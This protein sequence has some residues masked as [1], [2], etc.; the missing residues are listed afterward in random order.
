MTTLSYFRLLGA[1][2]TLVWLNTACETV[3][4]AKLDTSPTQ[5]SIDGT[6]TDQPG[7]QTVRLSLTAPYFDSATTP[8]AKGATVTVADNTGRTYVFTD[9]DNDG[10]YVWQPAQRDTMGRIGRTYKLT[11]AY[12]GDTYIASSTMNRVPAIDSLVFREARINP[13]SSTMGYRASFYARDF[14]GARDYYRVRFFWNG[15]LQ[16]KPRNIVTV[17]DAAFRGS[18]DTDGLQF[19][20]PIRQ[21]INPDSL[22]RM[23]DSVRVEVQSITPEAFDF[24]SQLRTQLT[25]GGLFATPP[26][27]LPTNIVNMTNGGRAATGFFTASAIRTR[28]AVVKKE[29]LR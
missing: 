27:N 16:N 29:N 15:V 17:Q 11:I 13:I 23:N 7:P 26:A 1:L 2:L 25:N 8:A 14:P 24:L 6:I 10:Y 3:I 19:I 22:Y 4:D 21:S 28:S 9:P 5:L 20:Q 12:Q 18:A